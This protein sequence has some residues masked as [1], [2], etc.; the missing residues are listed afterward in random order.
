[1]DEAGA[2]SG[3]GGTRPGYFIGWIP[4]LASENEVAAGLGGPPIPGFH[5]DS[6]IICKVMKIN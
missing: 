1:V 6:L 4:D 5:G 2:V 3:K